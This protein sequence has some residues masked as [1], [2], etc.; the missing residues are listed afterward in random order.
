MTGPD[1]DSTVR[2]VDLIAFARPLV[3]AD[4]LDALEPLDQEADLV[5]VQNM[6]AFAEFLTSHLTAREFERRARIQPL[7]HYT[8][9]ETAL[10]AI[11][12]NGSLRLGPPTR[13]N[14]PFESEPLW[15]SYSADAGT[16]FDD[17][18]SGAIFALSAEVSELM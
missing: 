3:D 11:L 14:D 2:R 9:A 6:S 13:M 10:D 1:G 4:V 7:F 5:G 8:S 17:V 18:D 12:T 15:P 16:S